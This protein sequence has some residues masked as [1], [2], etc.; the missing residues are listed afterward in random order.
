MHSADRHKKYSGPVKAVVLD[1]AGTA[2]DFGCM[3]PVS[4]F[5]E[6]FSRRGVEVTP[7]EAR[8]PMGLMKIDHI[9]AMCR[10][11][12][13]AAKW[14]EVFG[15]DP[16]EEDVRQMYEEVEPLMIATLPDHAR[17]VPGLLEAVANW[18]RWGIKIGTSTGYTR[19][20]MEILVPEA[21]QRGYSPDS[22]VCS[23]DVPQGRPFPFMCYQNAINLEV[24]PMEAM[25]KIG[26][27]VSDIQE[28]RNAGMWTIA[29]TR[30]SNEL[31]LT[32]AEVAALPMGQLQQRLRAIEARFFHAGAHYVV[33]DVGR[34][35]EIIEKITMRLT[36]GQRP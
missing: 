32:E 29:V 23:S 3:G 33:E 27:T 6:V 34:C 28:G 1:W 15:T 20:M 19:P 24:Y 35:T 22:I 30:T 14:K 5:M 11:P 25:V 7:G 8:G 31:G 26:D 36:A 2:V 16:N 12:S 13:V 9:R 21:A 10:L 18:R 17:P 4:P